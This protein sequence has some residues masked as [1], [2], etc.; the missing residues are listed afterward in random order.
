MITLCDR[1]AVPKAK[2]LCRGLNGREESTV[3]T[4]LEIPPRWYWSQ[5]SSYISHDFA[6]GSFLWPSGAQA[7]LFT[8]PGLLEQFAQPQARDSNG[9]STLHRLCLKEYGEH[10]WL[11]LD[12]LARLGHLPLASL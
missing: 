11:A 12:T 2:Q 5:S 6:R 4:I 1:L 9:S 3:A 8:T 10:P 7:C